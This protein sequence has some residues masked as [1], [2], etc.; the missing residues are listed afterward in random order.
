M[1]D[2]WHFDTL[3]SIH[4]ED[5]TLTVVYEYS[6]T[7]QRVEWKNIKPALGARGIIEV[8]GKG[9]LLA[10]VG[11][12]LELTAHGEPTITSEEPS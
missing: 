11:Y 6:G 1:S 3:R 9:S 8:P 5:G 4:Y 12:R 2:V 10:I 7:V